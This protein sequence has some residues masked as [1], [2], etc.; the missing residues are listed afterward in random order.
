MEGLTDRNE[1][2]LQLN[3]QQHKSKPYLSTVPITTKYFGHAN[4]IRNHVIKYSLQLYVNLTTNWRMGLMRKKLRK[5]F[6]SAI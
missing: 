1:R 2:Q 3:Q 6:Q 5:M 4:K